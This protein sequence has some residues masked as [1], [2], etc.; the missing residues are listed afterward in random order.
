ML[1]MAKTFSRQ[2]FQAIALYGIP[3]MFTGDG[4]AKAPVALA[5]GTGE[6]REKAVFRPLSPAEYLFVF[7]GPRQA[8]LGW[9][10]PVPHGAHKTP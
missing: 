2:P 10:P 6:Y 7:R 1:V 3:G 8:Q 5:V 4:H 9:E